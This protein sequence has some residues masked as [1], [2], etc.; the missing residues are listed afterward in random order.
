MGKLY[1][2]LWMLAAVLG[3]GV[4]LAGCKPRVVEADYQVVPL[5]KEITLGKHA[6]F[7]LTENTVIFLVEKDSLQREAAFLNEYLNDLLKIQLKTRPL[8]QSTAA[9]IFL[10]KDTSVCKTP[11]SYQI[12]ISTDKIV[13]RGADA[14]GVF[15]AIQTL[16]KSIPAGEKASTV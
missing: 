6:P 12:D 2:R 9:G 5:P 13:V 11:E 4:A 8:V 15:Y 16:R 14:A 3:V 1:A 7:Q 10:M